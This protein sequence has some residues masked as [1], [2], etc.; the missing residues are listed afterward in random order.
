MHVEKGQI[1]TEWISKEMNLRGQ[2]RHADH[3]TPGKSW[4]FVKL[5]LTEEV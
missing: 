3:P 4:G 5:V 2:V 1:W